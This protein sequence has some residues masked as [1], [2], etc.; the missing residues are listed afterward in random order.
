MI[1]RA[2]APPP[3]T[4]PHSLQLEDSLARAAVRRASRLGRSRRALQP[5]GC[6]NAR[7]QRHP[8][9]ARPLGEAAGAGAQAPPPA[10]LR[11][12][13]RG[14][15]R[16]SAAPRGE[17]EQRSAERVPGTSRRAPSSRSGASRSPGVNRPVAI[18]PRAGASPGRRRGR[19]RWRPPAG[20]RARL[21]L[22]VPLWFTGRHEANPQ[23]VQAD[24]GLRRSIERWP[25]SD[26]TQYD[27]VVLYDLDQARL[28]RIGAVLAGIDAEFGPGWRTAR[29][30]TW[31]AVDGADIVYCAV[32]VGGIAG[33]LLRRADRGGRGR[34]RPG[35]DGCRRH[36]V[37]AADRAGRDRDRRGRRPARARARCSSTSPTRSA[38]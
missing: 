4:N 32:R 8:R 37:R 2:R 17:V 33:R 25:S 16:R 18:P 14:A 29:P 5:D 10:P 31:R 34:D 9:L 12:T 36:H 15:R 1:G 21:T 13:S 22:V 23:S 3:S 20:S 38:S 35:D 11:R 27:E 24:S 26:A 19:C 7:R 30:A 28:D 6:S